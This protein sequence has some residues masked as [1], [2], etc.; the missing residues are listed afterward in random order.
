MMLFEPSA[1]LIN[2]DIEKEQTS[3][4]KAWLQ[5]SPVKKEYIDKSRLFLEEVA[6]TGLSEIRTSALNE[7]SQALFSMTGTQPKIV[8]HGGDKAGIIFATKDEKEILPD[9]FSTD[10]LRPE[11]YILHQEHNRMYVVGY[12]DKGLLYGVF[13]LLRLIQMEKN[14]SGLHLAESPVNQ[15][16]MINQWDNSDNSV[17]RGYAGESIFY[18]DLGFSRNLV[19]I[20]DYARLLASTGIN[21]I[22]INNVNVHQNETDFVTEKF[23]P[24]VKKVASIFRAYGIKTFLSANYAS[25]IT[26]G[27]LDTAD[28]LDEDVRKWWRN[29]A[30]RIYDYIPDF[31]GVVVKADSE[32]RPG[33][34]TYNRNH[35][36][37]ANMLG[38]A[39]EPFG[40]IVIWRC[41]VYNCKQDWRDRETDRA[42]AAYDHFMP[43]DGDFRE[44]VVLQIK[45][46]PMDF[47]VREPVSPLIG[48][49]QRTN[50]MIEFQ[51]AQEYTGQQR[52][53]CY[54]I[55]QWKEVLNF[56]TYAKGKGSQVKDIVSGSLIS[57]THCGIAAVSNIGNDANWT[58][59]T[60]AQANL[61]GYGRLTWN[62]DLTTEQITEEA[63]RLTFGND[64]EVVET[65]SEMLMG[66]WKTYEK[67]TSPLGVGWMIAPN[68]HYG[69]DIEGYEFSA[70]GTYHYSNRDGTGVNRTQ[71]SGTGFTGQYLSPNYEIYESLK[72]CPDELVL[73][74]HHVPYSHKLKSGDTV[75][76]H[77]YNTHF[78]GVEEVEAVLAGWNRLQDKVDSYRFHHVQNRL[79]EQLAHSKEWRDVINTYFYRKSGV[80]D[81]K[82]RK[83]YS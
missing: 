74:F 3:S 81:V 16:R 56:D 2:D 60:L 76:Q 55:P 63:V 9:G 75:I 59:H 45:N 46:G 12:C 5:Y 51:I 27:D 34:F 58:G 18:K 53:L 4:Y 13:H 40:G 78:E 48:G 72:S 6:L 14:V 10:E 57:Q 21:A 28:P 7:I 83:I 38:E 26:T 65:V 19:R 47:Q 29:T 42:R 33:P 79:E 35:A 67:Y 50:Q 69:P 17:E 64:R 36:D 30:E 22:S 52:H 73:F 31:G 61:Y 1:S 62:P 32:N 54:L 37:G 15:L 49:L 39:F 82:G 43:I 20:K 25:P 80:E 66:S 77:I 8:L 70:W 44:N 41:F 68:H 71:K 11:G 24:N 23:L